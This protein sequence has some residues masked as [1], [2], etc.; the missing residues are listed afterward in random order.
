LLLAC[1]GVYGVLAYLTNQRVPEMGVRIALGASSSNVIWLVLRQSLTMV[2]LGVVFGTA[3]ALGAARVLQRLVDGMQPAQ[4]SAF[5]ITL[6]VLVAAAL[7]ASFLPA[8]RASRIDPVIAL[9]QE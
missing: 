4:L 2:F 7:F 9:R 1:I 6:P 3:A 8:H 5:A